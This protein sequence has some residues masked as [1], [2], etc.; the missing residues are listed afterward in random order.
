MNVI[1]VNL[2]GE[3]EVS[4]DGGTA[5][6]TMVPDAPVSLV[7][8]L[9]TTTA[10]QIKISWSDGLSNGGAAI[11]DYRVSYDQSSGEFVVLESGIVD[12][13]YTT[14]VALTPGAFYL[15]TVEARN[16]VGFSEPSAVFSVHAV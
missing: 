6:I 15:F 1:A 10:S 7:N 11:I 4:D 12:Q 8:E 16:S 3:S 5:I 9:D 14:S 2:Y 13:D